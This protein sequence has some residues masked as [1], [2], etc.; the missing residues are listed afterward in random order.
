MRTGR[1]Q[2]HQGDGHRYRAAEPIGSS[3]S[4]K[5]RTEQVDPAPVEP[6]DPHRSGIQVRR[7]RQRRIALAIVFLIL[8]FALLAYYYS[9]WS[10][11]TR[12]ALLLAW[13][14][15]YAFVTLCVAW[16]RCPRCHRL[17]FVAKPFFRV[18][19]LRNRCG[20]CGWALSDTPS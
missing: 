18:N 8:P 14:A 13:V 16:S 15:V 5:N 10:S 3:G 12:S 1:L 4:L 11:S 6:F 17:Y 9:P 19:P 2:K 7:I 20:T